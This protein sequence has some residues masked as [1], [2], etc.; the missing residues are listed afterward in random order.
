MMIRSTKLMARF[1]CV[2]MMLVLTGI[3]APAGAQKKTGRPNIIF[4]LSDDAGYADFG[5][6]SNRLIPTPHI[7]RIATEGV[8]FSNAYVT[9]AVCSPSRAGILTGVNQ[10][11]FGQVYNF[12]QNV[13]YTIP[14]DSFGLPVNQ[15]LVG[16]YLKPLGYTTGIVGK[17]HEGFAERFHPNSRGFDYFW[18]FLWGSNNYTAGTAKK[19]EENKKPVAAEA[20]PYMT[21]AIGNQSVDFIRRNADKPFFLYVSF[22]APHTPMQAKPELLQKYE[23]KFGSKGRELNAAMTESMDENIGKILQEL[24]ARHLLDNT[25]IVF[26]NDNGGQVVHSFADNYPLRGM[27]GQ[28]YEG[29]IRVPMVLMWK[30]KVKAGTVYE[31]PVSTLDLLPAFINAAGDKAN[32]YAVLQGTDIVKLVNGRVKAPERA[33]YWYI[34]KDHGAIRKGNWKMDFVP[35]KAPQLYNLDTDI[36]E[37]RDLYNMEPEIAKQLSSLFY[38]WK[39]SLPKP[40]WVPLKTADEL[41]IQ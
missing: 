24:E 16:Q 17:W 35:G 34:A 9:G 19:V 38:K 20:I 28:V 6:Q 27:K 7:D 1:G 32:K 12:V 39:D 4:I 21:D 26:T 11:T 2:V 3:M 41:D 14:V 15:K 5:F 10:A 8:K 18:G 29:G 25:L 22:N 13:K 33:F 36:S 30:G 23:G 40:G 37:N 31:P